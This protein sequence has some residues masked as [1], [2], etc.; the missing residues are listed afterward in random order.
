M[1]PAGPY[2][3]WDCRYWDSVLNFFTIGYA[4]MTLIYYVD[5]MGCPAGPYRRVV[6]V[7][8]WIAFCIFSLLMGYASLTPIYNTYQGEQ[9]LDALCG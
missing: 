6:I 3:G 8:R 2:R 4:S 7:G 5:L 9:I 1:G